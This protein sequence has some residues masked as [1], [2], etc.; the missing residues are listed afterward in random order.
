VRTFDLDGRV[1]S[2]TLNSAAQTLHYDAVSRLVRV[3]DQ[4]LPTNDRTYDYDELNR[5]TSEQSPTSSLV[6]SY[7]AVGNRTQKILGGAV[8][9]YGYATD[10]NRLT[11]LQAVQVPSDANGSITNNG[12]S[13]FNYDARG[14]LVSANTAIG[15]VYYKINALGQRVQKVTPQG[16]TVYHYDIGGRLI[17]ESTVATTTD[18]VYI[19]GIPLAMLVSAGEAVNVYYIHTDQLDTPR[20]LSNQTGSIVW[21]W[22]SDGF[23]YAAANEQPSGQQP[24]RM[25]LRFS[26]QYYDKET[27]LHYN[28]L[29]DY[30][31][32]TGRYVQSDPIGLRGGINTYGYVDANPLALTD[33]TGLNPAAAGL[34]FIPTIG[35]AGCAAAVGGI[36]VATAMASGKPANLSGKLEGLWDKICAKSDD[37]CASINSEISST[38]ALLRE[39]YGDMRNDKFDMFNL[40]YN[41]RVAGIPGTWKGHILQY[42][43]LQM[44]LRNLIDFSKRIPCSYDPQAD[45]WVNTQPPLKP[46]PR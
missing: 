5:L 43:Q 19:D 34:C 46:L 35:W 32:Q 17:A 10:S 21:R 28:Y 26:G 42:N 39:K 12:T 4:T 37:A 20:V 41:T 40:A 27:N 29:R 15:Q 30:D 16:N 11:T 38:L 36:A 23:G 25:N 45:V 8:T 13:S 33:P 14:R 24:V 6:Y 31:P 44:R 3:S 7:D 2:Y 9:T 18:Y 22:D 1:T